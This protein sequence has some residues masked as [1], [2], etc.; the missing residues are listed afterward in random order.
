MA[1]YKNEQ[2][3]V[4][5]SFQVMVPVQGLCRSGRTRLSLLDP[6]GLIRAGG[7]MELRDTR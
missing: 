5:R 6:S 7:H 4:G 3:N 1:R 2:I